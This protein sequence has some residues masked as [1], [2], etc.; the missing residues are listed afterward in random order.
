VSNVCVI[1]ET[2]KGALCSSGNGRKMNERIAATI[3]VASIQL[4]C[5]KA[6]H[7]T[8]KHD[9][10]AY[11]TFTGQENVLKIHSTYLLLTCDAVHSRKSKFKTGLHPEDLRTR[12]LFVL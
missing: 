4:R 5:C 6:S 9:N 12:I 8:G 1:T 3:T 10:T 11:R 2:P 7:N